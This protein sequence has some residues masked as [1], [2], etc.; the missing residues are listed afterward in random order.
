M[1]SKK[2]ISCYVR[3]FWPYQYYIIAAPGQ[4]KL[5]T[6]QIFM[7]AVLFRQLLAEGKA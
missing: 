2:H 7:S 6:E 1:L 5:E 4:N 3:G